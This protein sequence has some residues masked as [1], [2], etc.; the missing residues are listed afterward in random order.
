M[1]HAFVMVKTGVGE[2]ERLVQ[3]IGDID[4]VREAH[5]VAGTYDIIVEIDAPEVYDVLK[6]AST[7]I[8]AL[9]GV[10][11]TRTYISLDDTAA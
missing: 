2:S 11:D 3:A 5:I 9:G 10:T 6:T 7:N 1:V 8:Q 4:S